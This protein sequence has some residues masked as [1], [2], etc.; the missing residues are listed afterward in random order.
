MSDIATINSAIADIQD[1]DSGS[2][3]YTTT[4]ASMPAVLEAIVEVLAARGVPYAADTDALQAL[5]NTEA[6]IAFLQGKGIVVYNATSAGDE[7]WQS[8]DGGYWC[9]YYSLTTTMLANWSDAAPT[10]GQVPVWNASQSKWV[11]GAMAV[12]DIGWSNVTSKPVITGTTNPAIAGNLSVGGTMAITGALTQTGNAA[13]G[14]TLGVTGNT[15]LAG[16]LQMATTKYA[17]IF[18]L[19]FEDPGISGSIEIYA[20]NAAAVSGG[21]AVGEVYQTATGELRIVV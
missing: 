15:T 3:E 6:Q 2:V 7:Q 8:T 21:L 13:L 4:E 20:N 17:R 10:N 5:T 9:L 16:E 19:L 11:P 1:T 12:T 18:K 14:G